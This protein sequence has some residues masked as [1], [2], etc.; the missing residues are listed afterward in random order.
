MGAGIVHG[1]FC[2]VDLGGSMEQRVVTPQSSLVMRDC[3]S[4]GN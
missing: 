1:A 4:L 3:V 2:P